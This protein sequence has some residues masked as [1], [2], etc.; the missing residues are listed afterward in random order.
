MKSGKRHRKI[1]CGRAQYAPSAYTTTIWDEE[2][3]CALSWC[4]C[5]IHNAHQ[6]HPSSR[7]Q[8]QRNRTLH[9][10]QFTQGLQAHGQTFDAF[11]VNLKQMDADADVC[12]YCLDDLAECIQAPLLPQSLHLV[13]H[14]CRN[15]KAARKSNA[16]LPTLEKQQSHKI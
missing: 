12:R 6:R 11:N 10:Q 1:I 5:W 4:P 8:P 3:G 9:C 15:Y 16:E 7:G 13:A 14:M 2:S